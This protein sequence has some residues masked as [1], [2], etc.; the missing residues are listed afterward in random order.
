MKSLHFR[1]M[2]TFTSLVEKV[3]GSFYIRGISDNLFTPKTE[4]MFIR[5]KVVKNDELMGK[6]KD[7]LF[8]RLINLN[9]LLIVKTI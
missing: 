9:V 8:R 1:I 6:N 3:A 4:S 5:S 7:L 2:F